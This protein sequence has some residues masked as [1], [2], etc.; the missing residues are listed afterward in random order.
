MARVEAENPSATLGSRLKAAIWICAQDA[1]E[2]LARLPDREMGWLL[3]AD[4]AAWP[5][6]YHSAKER[7]ESET[8]RIVELGERAEE[9]PLPKLQITD[10]T[11]ENRMLV[12]LGWLQHVRART[13]ARL[14]RDKAVFLALAGGKP[15]RRIRRIMG[16]GS[17]AAILAV[18]GKVLSQISGAIAGFMP[19]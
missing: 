8:S 13:P 3:S 10:I 6:V 11:A 17:D 2:T 4:R 16:Q 15:Y 1:A 5:E 9:L 14:R 19:E 7:F 18:K 12:V